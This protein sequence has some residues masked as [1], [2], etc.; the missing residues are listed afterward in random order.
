VIETSEGFR[1]TRAVFCG[2][3][4][5]G[6]SH[7]TAS[8]IARRRNDW[9]CTTTITIGE[10]MTIVDCAP[11]AAGTTSW[12]AVGRLASTSTKAASA[13]WHW[14][15]T[16]PEQRRLLPRQTAN[17]G[18]WSRL[19]VSVHLRLC[20]IS[21]KLSCDYANL[22]SNLDDWPFELKI[23]IQIIPALGERLHQLWSYTGKPC[24]T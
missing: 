17:S 20:L 11:E 1:L 21:F 24:Q 7:E 15:T 10:W 23:G 12:S 13:S 9:L 14:C 6:H 16:C 19:T 3:T 8:P 4:V 22:N 2:P 18:P 5:V